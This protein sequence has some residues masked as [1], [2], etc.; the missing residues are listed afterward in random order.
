MDKAELIIKMINDITTNGYTPDG[1]VDPYN[2]EWIAKMITEK[3]AIDEA[4]KTWAVGRKQQLDEQL[5]DIQAK[6]LQI[7]QD[8]EAEQS[9]LE[10]ILK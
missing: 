8:M 1:M 7:K 5:Q 3:G 10:A 4:L 9:A 6:Q 2:A